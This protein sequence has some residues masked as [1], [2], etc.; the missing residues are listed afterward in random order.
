MYVMC[1]H[2]CTHTHTLYVDDC[3]YVLHHMHV[4]IHAYMRMHTQNRT[5]YPGCGAVIICLGHAQLHLTLSLSLYVYIH[6]YV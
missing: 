6:T 3:A 4:Y 1:M 5:V 2:V